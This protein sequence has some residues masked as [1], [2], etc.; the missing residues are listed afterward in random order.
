MAIALD[1][2]IF[3]LHIKSGTGAASATTGPTSGLSHPPLQANSCLIMLQSKILGGPGRELVVP[4]VPPNYG[5][6]SKSPVCSSVPTPPISSSK[7]KGQSKKRTEER[8]ILTIPRI[9]PAF[10]SKLENLKIAST[11]LNSTLT[12]K[13]VPFLPPLDKRRYSH[14]TNSD[15]TQPK[16]QNCIFQNVFTE[17]ELMALRPERAPDETRRRHDTHTHFNFQLISSSHTVTFPNSVSGLCFFSS[18]GV[19]DRLSNT[20]T[21]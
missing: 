4:P 8:P 11:H 6:F 12:K 1:S 18:A 5:I 17:L 13:K 20:H 15:E 21:G 3:L 16:K 14:R 10:V 2:R 7:D 9:V 19:T